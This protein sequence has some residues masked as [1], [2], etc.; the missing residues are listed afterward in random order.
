MIIT[1]A[2]PY[3]FHVVTLKFYLILHHFQ[4]FDCW[5][6]FIFIFTLMTIRIIFSFNYHFDLY[7]SNRSFQSENHYNN[8]EYQK[9]YPT[10]EDFMNSEDFDEEKSKFFLFAILKIPKILIP[11][12]YFSSLWVL[13]KLHKTGFITYTAIKNRL[14]NL[15][16][17]T[18]SSNLSTKKTT[19]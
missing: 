2:F 9:M 18:Q 19:C 12:M 11:K 14:Y 1:S 10:W 3:A 4:D 16:F 17:S 5:H 7:Q 8:D 15:I 6:F 13:W